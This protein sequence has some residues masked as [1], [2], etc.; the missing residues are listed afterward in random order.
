MRELVITEITRPSPTSY[1]GPK[2]K[3]FLSWDTL[4][5]RFAAEKSYWVV[6]SYETPHTM[7]VWGV[8][9]DCA[10]RFSTSP[11]SRKAKNLKQNSNAIV[12]LADTE[13]VFSLHCTA[14]EITAEDELQTFCGEY[15]PKYRWNFKPTDVAGGAFALTPHTA[16]AWSAGEGAG[17]HD[18]ATRWQ[19]EVSD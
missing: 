2:E 11:V 1:F 15:N 3:G 6:T 7:P 19:F 18:T 14:A 16:F 9:H 8:W 5:W 10:F 17:F 13:A 12:H 4:I